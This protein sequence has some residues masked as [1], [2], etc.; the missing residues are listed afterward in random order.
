[1]NKRDIYLNLLLIFSI[2]G[3]IILLMLFAG[4][5]DPHEG[6]VSLIIAFGAAA[7][8][9]ILYLGI[10]EYSENNNNNTIMTEQEAKGIM[11]NGFAEIKPIIESMTSLLMEAYKKGIDVGM[12][13]GKHFTVKE[14]SHD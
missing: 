2:T 13:L 9:Y 4:K 12:K 10:P 8:F 6:S 14:K 3:W 5:I 1:M 7:L 11:D